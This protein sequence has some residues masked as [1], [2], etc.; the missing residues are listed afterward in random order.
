MKTSF[1]N[2]TLMFAMLMLVATNVAYAERTVGWFL[3]GG[4][5]FSL[6]QHNVGYGDYLQQT[7]T[8]GTSVLVGSVAEQR[9]MEIVLTSQELTDYKNAGNDKWQGATNLV[10]G[11]SSGNGLVELTS[12]TPDDRGL[13]YLPLID[14]PSLGGRFI[15]EGDV[16]VSQSVTSKAGGDNVAAIGMLR[17]DNA[18]ANGTSLAYSSGGAGT[19]GLAQ[20][21]VRVAEIN[22]QTAADSLG[23]IFSGQNV[24]QIC[25][26]SG[27]SM[28]ERIFIPLTNGEQNMT[29]STANGVPDF[30]YGV[31]NISGLPTGFDRIWLQWF[32]DTNSV[33][34]K[35]NNHVA[36]ALSIDL[37]DEHPGILPD[38]YAMS[39]QL[40]GDGDITRFA[41]TPEPSSVLMMCFGMLFFGLHTRRQRRRARKMG[42]MGLSLSMSS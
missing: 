5:T 19:A 8:S 17:N 29:L 35:I 37:D 1:R 40:Q 39:F 9:D 28:L 7:R 24:A 18:L 6:G 14:H 34:V 4:D 42:S 2:L 25:L 41:A 21:W 27:S 22:N 11:S 30:D 38:I 33:E 36:T 16:R 13:A 15:V 10:V 32:A 20:L 26:M 3:L 23:N 12:Q 31:S